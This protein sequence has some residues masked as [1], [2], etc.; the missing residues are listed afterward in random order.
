L[1]TVSAN[2]D[3]WR[4]QFLLGKLYEGLYGSGG[5][6]VVKKS[7]IQADKWYTVAI[8]HNSDDEAMESIADV[9]RDLEARMTDD[10]LNESLRLAKVWRPL[11]SVETTKRPIEE[12]FSRRQQ[13]ALIRVRCREIYKRT[14]LK[15]IASLTV[16]DAEQ[17][18]ACQAVHLYPPR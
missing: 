9:R 10:E 17:V 1:A 7:P 4:A 11:S 8:N 16:V 12:C 5:A 2:G 15:T 13:E 18:Q 3:E 14:S 6:T